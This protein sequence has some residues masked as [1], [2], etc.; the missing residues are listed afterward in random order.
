MSLKNTKE[1]NVDTRFQKIGVLMERYFDEYGVSASIEQIA[2]M[3]GY[4]SDFDINASW[5]EKHDTNTNLNQNN[6]AMNTQDEY[7]SLLDIKQNKGLSMIVESLYQELKQK[8]NVHIYLK[9]QTEKIQKI[10]S[11][12]IKCKQPDSIT[13]HFKCKTCF[14]ALPIKAIKKIKGNVISKF[15][16]LLHSIKEGDYIRLY[17]HF[18]IG[19]KEF[20][21]RKGFP[22]IQM[23][24]IIGN[25]FL[26]QIVPHEK[27]DNI[28]MI[29][30]CEDSDV[31]KLM[32]I[33]QPQN[34][35]L[36]D[37]ERV[38]Q[39]LVHYI[40]KHV[41]TFFEWL[42]KY[43]PSHNTIYKPYQTVW[44]QFLTS[45][46]DLNLGMWESVIGKWNT[47]IS[48][49]VVHPQIVHPLDDFHV[50]GEAVSKYNHGWMEGALETVLQS[51]ERFKKHEKSSIKE[52]F[53]NQLSVWNKL[54]PGGSKAICPFATQN[55]MDV[56]KTKMNDIHHGK[57]AFL[58]M[59]SLSTKKID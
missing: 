59:V 57:E 30:Y 8:Q 17:A 50:M 7:Y 5:F 9:T 22:F 28:V 51:V 48:I 3:Y 41:D 19:Y 54:H 11:Y 1:N 39:H 43:S 46:D 31:S 29:S 47:R 20:L 4:P 58:T 18:S 12:H 36:K 40:E 10:N 52:P 16:H 6:G 26:G 35:S 55:N 38:N 23:P 21:K 33:I 45:F 49:D 37:K 44:K 56:L 34:D 32:D 42:E 15:D 2:R 14:M 13:I 25:T 27:Y 53:Y 24:K